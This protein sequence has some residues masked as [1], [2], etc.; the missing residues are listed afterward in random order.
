MSCFSGANFPVKLCL[1][2]IRTSAI[3]HA[4]L[5]GCDY[6]NQIKYRKVNGSLIHA[7]PVE[8]RHFTI[9]S[10]DFCDALSSMYSLQDAIIK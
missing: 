3:I 4:S 10:T 5:V 6:A 1:L 2:R 9:Q 7:S 8:T